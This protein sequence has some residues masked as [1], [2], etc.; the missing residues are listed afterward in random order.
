M[1]L[2]MQWAKRFKESWKNAEDEGPKHV[3]V[4]FDALTWLAQVCLMLCIMYSSAIITSQTWVPEISRQILKL[5]MAKIAGV[6]SIDAGI[7]GVSEWIIPTLFMTGVFLFIW[8]AAMVI[9]WKFLDR[10]LSKW[11]ADYKVAAKKRHQAKLDAK[12]EAAAK[13]DVKQEAAKSNKIAK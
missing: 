7:I 1:K 2:N 5:A 3:G 6:N 10:H 13:K 12:K 9:I 4:W 8:A 11:R